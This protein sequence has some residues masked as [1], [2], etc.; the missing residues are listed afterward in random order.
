MDR[1]ER[2]FLHVI[3]SPTKTY[4]T[5][6]IYIYMYMKLDIHVYITMTRVW[7]SKLVELRLGCTRS[8]LQALACTCVARVL[9]LK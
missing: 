3:W 8:G 9:Y 5:C 2:M 7:L 4:C 1:A 6:N